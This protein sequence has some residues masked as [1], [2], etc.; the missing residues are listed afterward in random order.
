MADCALPVLERRGRGLMAFLLPIEIWLARAGRNAVL[1]G[2]HDP[3]HLVVVDALAAWARQLVGA[4]FVPIV[5]EVAFVERH[6]GII[7][8]AWRLTRLG[9]T[10]ASCPCSR[11]DRLS[12]FL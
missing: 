4:R 7:L 1:L 6:V 3:T 10:P 12:S 9:P 11:C 5:E 2:A 8:S